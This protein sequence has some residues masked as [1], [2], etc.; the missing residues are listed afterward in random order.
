MKTEITNLIASLPLD[1][2]YKFN[3]NVPIPLGKGVLVKKIEQSAILNV[4]SIMIVGGENTHNPHVGIIQSVGPNCSEN[5]RVG[6]RC[7]Y[8]FYVDSSFFVDGVHYAKMDEVD[9]YYIIPPKTIV[10][11]NIKSSEEVR[12][13]KKYSE[14]DKGMVRVHKA[15]QN[16]KDKKQDKTRGKVKAVS[17]KYNLKK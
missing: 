6:L 17:I 14:Y 5:L 1:P 13:E 2:E 7:Y 8:N 10:F 16:E 9:V 4:G 12:R 15:D 11:E 3:P